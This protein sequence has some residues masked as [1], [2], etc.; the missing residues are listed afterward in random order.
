MHVKR[1]ELSNHAADIARVFASIWSISLLAPLIHIDD[2][3]GIGGGIILT[4]LGRE[5]HSSP[6]R[7]IVTTDLGL[8]ETVVGLPFSNTNAPKFWV[9]LHESWVATSKHNARFV[10]CG[11]RVYIGGLSEVSRHFLRLEWVAPEVDKEGIAVYQGAHAGHPH[12]HIDRAALVGPEEHWRSL[13][14]LTTPV[15]ESPI[16]VFELKSAIQEPLT[17]VPDLSW[18]SGVHLPAQ[19][20]WMHHSWNGHAL[21]APHQSAPTS[22]QMLKHWWEGSLR[23]LF[24]ELSQHGV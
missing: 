4:I 10:G 1:S 23:Y 12:W 16:E 18:L 24:V 20:Q 22:L 14:L 21:P 17:V 3:V 6:P 8:S 13:E 11:L 19:A 15:S 2:F 5:Q 9:G 7:R